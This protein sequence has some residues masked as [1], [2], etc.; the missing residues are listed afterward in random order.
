M[1][2]HR[3][4][5][6]TG[7]RA[8]GWNRI[9]GPSARHRVER[10]MI[11]TG[12]AALPLAAVLAAPAAGAAFSGSNG[13]IA[14]VSTRA[15]GATFGGIFQVNSQYAE[16]PG[17][18]T[19]GGDQSA[20]SGLTNGGGGSGNDTEP[21][22]S[23]SGGTVFFSSSG[24]AASDWTIYDIP[25]GSPEPP[26]SPTELSQASGS[27]SHND[28]A[29]SVASDGRTVVFNRDDT[30]LDTL[31]ASAGTPSSTVCTLYTPAPTVGLQA[32]N[33]STFTTS[34]A[35]FNPVDPTQLLY[36]GGDNHLH[37]L[38]RLPAPSATSPSNP[39]GAVAGQSGVTDTDLSAAAIDSLTA[40][41]D[42]GRY[43]DENADWS[44][45]GTKIVFDSNRAGGSATGNTT[46]W[47][48]SNISSGT[49]TVTPLWSS[50]VG[51]GGGKQPQVQPVYSPDGTQIAF[52]QNQ[53]GQNT[54]TG[55]VVGAGGTL[56]SALNVSQSTQGTG[57]INDQPDWG[58]GQP[59]TGTPEVPAVM[60]LPGA[61]LLLGG[62]ALV[63]ERR[64]RTAGIAAAPTR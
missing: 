41:T 1:A 13:N 59:G 48:M 19:P 17:L 35:V 29:P 60:M 55:S 28:Y 31:D 61:A 24:N 9:F 27:E 11:A 21:F 22:Y 15:N 52:V 63:V 2:L 30:S 46:L 53:G 39:C 64:R 34:R 26:G 20:T 8:A 38:K 12:L 44:P 49:L 33:T 32:I 56:S 4:S 7:V 51:T 37:L 10:T 3:G 50:Q 45:D 42:S 23:P 5:V 16:S 62:L 25:T 36:V 40:G 43:I 58:P 14:F 57:I 6:K 18:G 54:W 47:R